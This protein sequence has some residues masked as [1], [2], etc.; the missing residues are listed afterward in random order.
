M[1]GQPR[2]TL[3]GQGGK[4]QI[5]NQHRINPGLA[6]RHQNPLGLSQFVGKNQGVERHITAQSAL[7][8]HSHDL[9]KILNAEVVGTQSRIESLDA[10]KHGIRTIFYGRAHHLW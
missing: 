7:M 2:C 1:D 4:A 6:A 5:L 3:V 10:K 9:R 8:E